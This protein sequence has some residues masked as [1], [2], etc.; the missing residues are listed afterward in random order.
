MD[1][2]DGIIEF[3]AVAEKQGFSAAAQELGCSTSHVSR[4]VSR[5]EQRLGSALVARTTRLVSLTEAGNLY[6]QQCRELLNGLQ[7]AN[8]QLG[9]QQYQLSGVLRVS[10]AG[11]FSETYVMPALMEFARQHPELKL[12]LDFNTHIVNFVESGFDFA[13]R[14]GQLQDSGLVARK[15]VQ[16][17]M[18]AVASNDY[19]QQFGTPEHPDQLRQHQ[20]IY[21]NDQW[22]FQLADRATSVK[23]SGRIHTN[24]QHALVNACK[25]GL[26]IAYMPRRNLQP[27]VDQGLAVPVLEPYWYQG[28]NNWVVYPNRRFLPAR[29]RLAINYLL[30]HFADWQE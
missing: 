21:N 8:E 16:R 18:M 27:L 7:Q 28:I 17:S 3:V 10:L 11:T 29:A 14:F 20:C 30:Q 13:I 6:Y 4:Q 26:G 24:N 2:F 25:S 23:V 15:L 9:S 1:S 19:L 5:L 22:T 12:Q